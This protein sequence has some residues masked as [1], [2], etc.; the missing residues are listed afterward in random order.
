MTGSGIVKDS[1]KHMMRADGQFWAEAAKILD[2][3]LAE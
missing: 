1:R 3:L 2:A